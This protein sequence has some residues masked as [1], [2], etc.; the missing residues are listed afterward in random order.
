MIVPNW[1]HSNLL[2]S[3]FVHSIRLPETSVHFRFLLF[4]SV[5]SPVASKLLVQY[6]E[7]SGWLLAAVFGLIKVKILPSNNNHKCRRYRCR[8]LAMLRLLIILKEPIGLRLEIQRN[9]SALL[10]RWCLGICLSCGWIWCQRIDL[11]FLSAWGKHGEFDGIDD[12]PFFF[13]ICASF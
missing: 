10:S 1:M 4:S 11:I 2:F 5:H 12:N 7:N 8:L 13:E 9:P 3:M 6:T